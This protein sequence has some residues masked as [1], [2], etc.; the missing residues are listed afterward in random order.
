MTIPSIFNK[1]LPAHFPARSPGSR[2]VSPL[3]RTSRDVSPNSSPERGGSPTAELLANQN[4]LSVSDIYLLLLGVCLGILV[5]SLLSLTS[6]Q[7]EKPY[8][9]GLSDGYQLTE[10][11][12]HVLD[13]RA[14]FMRRSKTFGHNVGNPTPSRKSSMLPNRMYVGVLSAKHFIP[15]R[16]TA[17]HNAWGKH[18]SPHIQVSP[19]VMFVLWHDQ[20]INYFEW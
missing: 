7:Q 17:V 13:T 5:A 12:E 6:K 16:V 4:S 20:I 18:L 1:A 10:S 3:R 11:A 14:E 19:A 15:T 9:G 2:P 8:F